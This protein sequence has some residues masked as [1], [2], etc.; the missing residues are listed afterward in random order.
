MATICAFRVLGNP[1]IDVGCHPDIEAAV[2]A[3]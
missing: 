3:K 2:A 1:N